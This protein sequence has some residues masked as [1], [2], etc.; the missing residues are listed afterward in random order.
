MDI[1]YKLK[2]KPTGLWYK[3]GKKN[4]SKTGKIYPNKKTALSYL[5]QNRS[6]TITDGQGKPLRVAK[7]DFELIPFNLVPYSN[8]LDSEE[9]H[10]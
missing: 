1:V 4:L 7:E 3:P 6:M 5:H 8:R 10:R 2:Y 9:S